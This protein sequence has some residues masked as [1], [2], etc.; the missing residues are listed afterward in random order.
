MRIRRFF[1]ALIMAAAPVLVFADTAPP[2]FTDTVPE[3]ATLA[4]LGAGVA[5]LLISRKNKRK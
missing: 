1:V 5:A 4:L 3:P 2:D